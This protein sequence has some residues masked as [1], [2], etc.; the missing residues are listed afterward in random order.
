MPT[1]QTVSTCVPEA[2][3][4]THV[5]DIFGYSQHRGIGAGNPMI[6]GKFYVGGPKWHVLFY[7]DGFSSSIERYQNCISVG[8]ALASENVKVRASYELQLVDQ[9]TGLR[10]PVYKAALRVFIRDDDSSWFTMLLQKR[11]VFE[12]STYLR[13]DHV[14]IKCIVTVIKEPMMPKTKPF[15]EIEVLPSNITEHFAKRLEENEGVNVNFSVGENFTVHKIVLAARS[16]VFKAKLY[17]PMR[18]AG[19]SPITI[20]DVQPDVFKALLHSIY[21]ETL[22]PMDDLEGDDH[23]EMICR[24]LVGTTLALADQHHCDMLKDACI[25]FI[26]CSNAVEAV[27]STQG[28]KMPKRTC[29]SVVIDALEKSTSL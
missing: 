12:T 21:T 5:F 17:G 4:G 3:Q 22:P 26:T 2:E 19:T 29:P 13:D 27:V 16:T 7:P 23:S 18:E 15:P 1:S 11:S 6:S 8:L 20:K 9:S 24:L 10:V 28:Y 14:T 25:K